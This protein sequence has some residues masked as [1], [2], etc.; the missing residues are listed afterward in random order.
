MP[1][2]IDSLGAIPKKFGNILKGTCITVEIEQVQRTDLS[3]TAR[4]LRKVLQI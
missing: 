2:V 3:G 1:L 4:I